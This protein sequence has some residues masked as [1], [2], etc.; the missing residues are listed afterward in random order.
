VHGIDELGVDFD[1]LLDLF[2]GGRAQ[3]GHLVKVDQL[4][5][6]DYV[7]GGDKV[8]LAIGSEYD[9]GSPVEIDLQNLGIRKCLEFDRVRS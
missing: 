9:G 7:V 3:K 1:S 5:G 8:H 4:S 6:V 2:L